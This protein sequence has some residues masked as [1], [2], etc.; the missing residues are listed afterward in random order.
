MLFECEK[1]RS[2]FVKQKS[3]FSEL[4]RIGKT[5]IS[6]ENPE[7]SIKPKIAPKFDFAWAIYTAF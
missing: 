6:P 3:Y 1:A 4:I 7:N 5:T 2:H